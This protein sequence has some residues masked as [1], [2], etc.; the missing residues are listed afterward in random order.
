L[1]TIIGLKYAFFTRYC[2]PKIKNSH[3]ETKSS[4]SK[5]RLN[6]HD[7]FCFAQF[8]IDFFNFRCLLLASRFRVFHVTWTFI[9]SRVDN[10]RRILFTWHIQSDGKLGRFFYISIYFV[11]KQKCPAYPCIVDNNWSIDDIDSYDLWLEHWT[12]Q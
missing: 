1:R 6:I 5:G 9:N 10:V 11:H 7:H 2:S 8:N 12:T 3:S 4:N